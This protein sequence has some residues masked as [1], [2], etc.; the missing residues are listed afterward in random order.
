MLSRISQVDVPFLQRLATEVPWPIAPMAAELVL[1]APEHASHMMES[2]LVIF[3]EMRLPPSQRFGADAIAVERP[4]AVSSAAAPTNELVERPRSAEDEALS[5]LLQN[6]AL[7]AT[8][9]V[10][11]VNSYLPKRYGYR[12]NPVAIASLFDRAQHLGAG[13]REGSAES[14]RR[15]RGPTNSDDLRVKLTLTHH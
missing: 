12:S 8:I 15:G 14:T 9:S 6:F 13:V 3:N 1:S 11:D 4:C 2:I 10:T 5:L 7:N